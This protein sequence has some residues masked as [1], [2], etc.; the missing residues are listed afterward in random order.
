MQVRPG[1][2]NRLG[3]LPAWLTP[4]DLTFLLDRRQTVYGYRDRFG[5]DIQSQK[6]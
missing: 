6:S 3:I 1:N 5:V 4:A 2:D